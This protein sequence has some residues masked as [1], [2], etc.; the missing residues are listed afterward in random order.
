MFLFI[1]VIWRRD[2]GMLL[3]E[4]N[5]VAVALPIRLRKLTGC[6]TTG[7]ISAVFGHWAPL[8]CFGHWAPFA[9]AMLRHVLFLRTL[10]G[11][12]QEA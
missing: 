6:L 1:Y 4:A 12:A 2:L 9:S 10:G 11:C 7:H 5:M 8:Q 3:N